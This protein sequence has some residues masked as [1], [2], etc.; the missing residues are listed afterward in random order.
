VYPL[1][2]GW[3]VASSLFD[4]CLSCKRPGPGRPDVVRD[5]LAWA[6]DPADLPWHLQGAGLSLTV[7]IANRGL[8]PST[9]VVLRLISSSRERVLA[10]GTVPS[11]TGPRRDGSVRWFLRLPE[12]APRG[13]H[14][15]TY[16]LVDAGGQVIQPAVESP[17]AR[18]VVGNAVPGAEPASDGKRAS[19]SE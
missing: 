14:H 5:M 17:G 19:S 8:S 15:V 3:V 12:D 7:P 1:G 13:I 18:V 4:D 6:R 2:H 10:E 11:L 9:S 16:A